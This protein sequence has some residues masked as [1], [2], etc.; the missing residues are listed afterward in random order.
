MPPQGIPFRL[1]H[2]VPGIYHVKVF[3][4]LHSRTS[5]DH[6]GSRTCRNS[7]PTAQTHAVIRLFMFSL[8]SV[9]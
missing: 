2:L 8:S 4:P 5:S 9:L 6:V 7:M 1:W 3:D